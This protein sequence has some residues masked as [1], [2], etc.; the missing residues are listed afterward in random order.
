MKELL[1]NETLEYTDDSY[2]LIAIEENSSVE[3]A[4]CNGNGV[5]R[6]LG[7]TIGCAVLDSACSTTVFGKIWLEIYLE[8]LTLT[9][10]SQVKESSSDKIF[11]FG[12]GSKLNSLKR[13]ITPCQIS[14]ESCR[15]ATEVVDSDISLLLGKPSLKKAGVVLDLIND[16][17]LFF[18]KNNNLE[19]S[20]SGHYFTP[21]REHW[22]LSFYVSGN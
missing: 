4:L 6:L 3:I 13:V 5:T 21:L 17:A 1:A 12:A 19:V 11:K 14:T 22:Q 15:I 18:G 20:K 8:S 2:V 7:G 16:E 9:Q 10:C